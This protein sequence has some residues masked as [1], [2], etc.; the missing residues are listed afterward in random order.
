[1]DADEYPKPNGALNFSVATPTFRYAEPS[2]QIAILTQQTAALAKQ[3]RACVYAWGGP[4]TDDKTI[5]RMRCFPEDTISSSL[6]AVLGFGPPP[7]SEQPTLVPATL[8]LPVAHC[9][10]VSAVYLFG[11][12]LLASH[13]QL[14]QKI[15]T[16]RLSVP[17]RALADTTV[18]LA[19]T[20]VAATTCDR[21]VSVLVG[22]S[23]REASNFIQERSR[24]LLRATPLQT[25][26]QIWRDS[27]QQIWLR[28]LDPACSGSVCLDGQGALCR[29][30]HAVLCLCL[31]LTIA[32]CLCLYILQSKELK[33]SRSILMPIL[34]FSLY[35]ACASVS[36]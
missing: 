4:K 21:E 6:S 33:I 22:C 26:H 5:L 20:T 8:Y 35:I 31:Y 12:K 9:T 15:G 11:C 17:H 32:L 7:V 28:D 18:A 25:I 13:T 27:T 29:A 10:K 24:R 3:Q 30:L 16:L 36:I 23:S 19:D 14:P 2:D 34:R 1:M